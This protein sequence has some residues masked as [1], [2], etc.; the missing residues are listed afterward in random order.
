[1]SASNS[2]IVSTYGNRLR[3][4]VCGIYILE[5]KLLLVKHKSLGNSGEFWAPPGGGMEYGETSSQTLTREFK[6]ETGLTLTQ[7]HFAFTHEYIDPPLQALEL[8]YVIEEA[9]GELIKGLDPEMH[10]NKQI[11]QEVCF[12]SMQE[13]KAIPFHSKHQVLQNLNSIEELSS[14]RG[15]S[16]YNPQGI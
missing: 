16:I 4:R 5:H 3:V 6:E 7:F 12:M 1:M 13:I 15:Y 10:V 8:Y 14:Q 2:D 9:K 11:I